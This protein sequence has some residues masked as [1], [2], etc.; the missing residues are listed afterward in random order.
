MRTT[1][2]LLLCT[3]VF[4]ALGCGGSEPEAV[5]ATSDDAVVRDVLGVLLEDTGIPVVAET[6]DEA[7]SFVMNSDRFS[8]MAGSPLDVEAFASTG[9]SALSEQLVGAFPDHAAQIVSNTSAYLDTL[10]EL[11]AYGKA[12]LDRVPEEDRVVADERLAPLA[13][14][15]ITVD[16]AGKTV[17]NLLLDRPAT[18]GYEST[19]VGMMDY[20]F[21]TLATELGAAGIDIHGMTGKLTFGH[22]HAH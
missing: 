3:T 14:Y 13:S 11:A 20:N 10:V 8:G 19:Y 18:L 1:P 21:T 2:L 17:D 6:Q 16:P 15:G 9:V 7:T 12:T 5:R 22:D 4:L